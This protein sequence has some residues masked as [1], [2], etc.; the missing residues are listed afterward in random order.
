MLRCDLFLG[1]GV[2]VLATA[3]FSQLAQ[4]QSSPSVSAASPAPAAAPAPETPATSATTSATTSGA[5]PAVGEIVV[6]AQR[7]SQRLQD[8]PV[9]VTAI[10]AETLA[11]KGITSTNDLSQLTP[12]LTN[13]VAN[14]F[15]EPSLRGIGTQNDA[16]GATGTVAVY[17]DGVYLASPQAALFSYNNISQ[18]EVDKGP[19][20]TLFGRN[21]T[22]GVIQVQTLDPKSTFGGRVSVGTDNYDT[23]TGDFYVTGPVLG[24]LAADLAVHYDNQLEGYGKNLL[25][26]NDIYKTRNIDAR[27]KWLWRPTDRDRITFIFDYEDLKDSSDTLQFK[28]VPYD[29]QAPGVPIPARLQSQLGSPWNIFASGDPVETDRQGGASVEIDHRFD[30]AHLIDIAAY[31]KSVSFLSSP[32]EVAPF[33]IDAFQ[34]HDDIQ[35]SEEVR[36]ASLETSRIAWVV[37]FYY[38]D[39][40]STNS[41]Y[42][43]INSG[44]NYTDP[45]CKAKLC[46]PYPHGA[47][48]P[49]LGSA[50]APS[51]PI[52]LPP[53]SVAIDDLIGSEVGSTSYA[54]YAQTTIP[55][56]FLLPSLNLTAGVRY[57]S[58]TE[59]SVGE[60]AIKAPGVVVTQPDTDFSRL[61]YKVGLD[62]H[63]THAVLAYATYS[64][65]FQAGF[66]N[67]NTP[68]TPASK[69][70]TIDDYE[71]G[72][73]SSF[74]DRRAVLNVGGFYYDYSNIVEPVFVDGVATTTNGPKAE[75]YGVDIDASLIVTPRF[76][77]SASAEVLHS[78]WTSFPN[79]ITA[80]PATASKPNG[81]CI[82]LV[83]CNPLGGVVSETINAK[84]NE[85]PY[86]PDYVIS[87]TPSYRQPVP[88]GAVLLT[89]TWYYNNGFY[90]DASNTFGQTAYNTLSA[91]AEWDPENA[92]YS[93]KVWAKNMTDTEIYSRTAV[94]APF[95][96]YYA[97][98]PPRTYGVSFNY[99]F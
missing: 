93:V 7:R 86:A 54:G 60:D 19:Q 96:E 34:G 5:P 27:S 59:T 11:A 16:A 10:T 99:R 73:K 38:L 17:V 23:P 13:F 58:E 71:V 4:A 3:A 21:A 40:T 42:T 75:L 84:G 46:P 78:E 44:S 69:P 41:P 48:S 85:L 1:A 31:R 74:L 8:V 6:T 97:L 35:V 92:P 29:Y 18:V 62:Y 20:G 61:T 39:S 64:T 45:T 91:E 52:S 53:N 43:L 14:G 98:S 26:G 12:G 25:T 87:V 80:I 77:I 72:F 47:L 70:Q 32:A 63:F 95:G 50:T 30:F 2:A 37:G 89:A 28:G 83:D 15:V 90:N 24:D 88:G 9:V 81:F 51:G 22:A 65:G 79:A 33:N 68:T 36:L 56:D 67:A 76:K 82:A 66:F 55:L 49:L 94:S 57:T